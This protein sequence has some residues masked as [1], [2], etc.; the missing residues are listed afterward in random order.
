MT[1]GE[2]RRALL[3]GAADAGQAHLHVTLP[4][5]VAGVAQRVGRDHHVPLA[6]LR[7]RP[8]HAG[9]AD[10]VASGQHVGMDRL[11]LARIGE[12]PEVPDEAGHVP[13]GQRHERQGQR[14]RSPALGHGRVQPGAVADREVDHRGNGPDV[15]RTGFRHIS[16]AIGGVRAAPSAGRAGRG[17]QAQQQR[18]RTRRRCRHG[19]DPHSGSRTSRAVAAAGEARL[20]QRDRQ[21]EGVPWPET[22]DIPAMVTRKRGSVKLRPTPTGGWQVGGRR[23]NI[24]G[25]SDSSARTTREVGVNGTGNNGVGRAGRRGPRRPPCPPT[26]LRRSWRPSWPR[27]RRSCGPPTGNCASRCSGAAACCRWGCVPARAP[28]GP[29]TSTWATGTTACR[30]S[31]PIWRRCAGECRDYEYEWKGR[32][33]AARTEPLRDESGD[34]DRGAGHR[35]WTSPICGKSRRPRRSTSASWSPPASTSRW[36]G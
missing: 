7:G 11:G 13:R 12:I 24:P 2:R 18:Q 29:S 19:R 5:D 20:R 1:A 9:D 34:G 23:A 28:G 22:R 35:A 8:R 10:V 36:P 27:L 33:L 17:T 30:P 4:I 16:A 21:R 32:H 31:P 25:Q 14:R 6:Q 3:G 15:V 26:W